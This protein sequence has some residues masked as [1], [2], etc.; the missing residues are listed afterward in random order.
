VLAWCKGRS[1]QQL[2][3]TSRFT[4]QAGYS[5]F[6]VLVEAL[7]MRPS[8]GVRRLANN[9]GLRHHPANAAQGAKI[10]KP[11]ALRGSRKVNV[12]LSEARDLDSSVAGGET[13]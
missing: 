1:C 7:S 12:I 9:K 6:M 5:S 13:R 8:T 10:K 2:F 3:S 4:I 11:L